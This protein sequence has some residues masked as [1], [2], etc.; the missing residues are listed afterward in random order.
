MLALLLGA[1]GAQLKAQIRAKGRG[2]RRT[3]GADRL[4]DKLWPFACALVLLTVMVADL[5]QPVDAGGMWP[6]V[7]RPAASRKPQQ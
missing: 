5:C 3:P 6:V 7:I 1:D 2:R 4:G